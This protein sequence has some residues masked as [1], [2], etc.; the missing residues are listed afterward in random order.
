MKRTT[1]FADRISTPL[2]DVWTVADESGALL[3]LDFDGGRYAPEN[4][5]DFEQRYASEGCRLEWRPAALKPLARALQ[6]YFG[7][8]LRRFDLATDPR[9]SEFQRRVWKELARIPYG[10]MV[11]YAQLA[12]RIGRPGAARAVGRANATNP[13]AVVVPCHRVV[14]ADGSLTGYAGG[15]ERKRALLELEGALVPSGV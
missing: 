13:V 10:S 7:G 8:E 12:E 1:V 5:A 2:G 15:I 11:S 6:S 4:E 14:G 9:G 3:Q